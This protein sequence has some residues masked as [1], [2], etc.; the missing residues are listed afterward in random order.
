M[1]LRVTMDFTYLLNP[2][3]Q[4]TEILMPGPC[5][6]ISQVSGVFNVGPAEVMHLFLK[7]SEHMKGPPSLMSSFSGMKAHHSHCHTVC[8]HRTGQYAG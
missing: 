4:T 1:L 8:L 7:T 3:L 6:Y 5:D 2:S